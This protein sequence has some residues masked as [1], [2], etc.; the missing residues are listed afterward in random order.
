MVGYIYL[1]L[2]EGYRVLHWGVEWRG[3]GCVDT[4]SERYM[5][6]KSGG[7]AIFEVCQKA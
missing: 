2:K 1:F 7:L 6:S 5:I 4:T 3:V